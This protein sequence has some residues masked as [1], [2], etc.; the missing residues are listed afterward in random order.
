MLPVISPQRTAMS[1][2]VNRKNV[3]AQHPSARLQSRRMLYGAA[4]YVVFGLV[5]FP[6]VGSTVGTTFVAGGGLFLW[7]ALRLARRGRALQCHNA[8]V[9]RIMRGQVDEAE[10]LL[11]RIPPASRWRH[12]GRAIGLQ[13]ALIAFYRGDAELAVSLATAA[14]A[15]PYA[16]FQLLLRSYEEMHQARLLAIR[17]L[18]YASMGQ[19][20]LA[21]SDATA[22]EASPGASPDVLARAALARAVTLA[23]SNTTEA[24]AVHLGQTG[25][26]MLEFLTPRERAVVRALR[27]LARARRKSIYREAAR[28]DD[29]ASEEARLAAWIGKLAPGA[30][31]FVVEGA[32]HATAMPAHT[33]GAPASPEAVR[34]VQ[35]ARKR[36]QKTAGMSARK[37]T[38]ILWVLLVLLFASIWQFLTPA[39]TVAG[40]SAPSWALAA[41]LLTLAIL[42]VVVFAR[43]SAFLGGHRQLLAAQRDIARGRTDVAMRTLEALTRTSQDTNSAAAHLAMAYLAER[44]SKWTEAIDHCSRGIARLSKSALLKAHSSDV[45][46]PELLSTRA[47]ALV[48]C[49]REAEAAAEMAVVSAECPSY[50]HAARAHFRVALLSAVRAGDLAKAA[51][52]ARG[53]APELPLS[54]RDDMLADLI[55]AATS[56]VSKDE[57]ERIN[58]E[59][60]DDAALRAWIDDVGPGLREASRVRVNTGAE[61]EGSLDHEE[62]ALHEIHERDG[63]ESTILQREME[64]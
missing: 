9:E 4:A 36:A 6:L 52:L 58:G 43:R 40:E 5:A 29:A 35:Q 57:R 3:E 25:G 38:V 45:L 8:A 12:L 27:R 1:R 44:S 63:S 23:R 15:V 46:F 47:F 14:I 21:E 56:V 26:L 62:D 49:G 60:D 7:G 34:E 2:V 53:R 18:S 17:A 59:L 10:A 19:A 48:A 22:S 32:G 11:N 31:A 39:S 50:V 33:A 20:V 41:T 64:S 61:H 30:Q 24:L 37:T 28:P 51:D 54:L 16:R 42:F 13:R 55:L